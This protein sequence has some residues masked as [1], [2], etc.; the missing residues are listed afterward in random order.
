MKVSD[1]MS[2]DLCTAG[3]ESTLSDAA[4]LMGEHGVGSVL[5]L[6]GGRLSGILTERDIV[7]ALST[8]HDGPMRPATEWMTKDPVTVTPHV[9]VRTAL[10]TMIEGG[11]RHLPVCEGDT[12]IGVLSIRDVAA[13][14]AD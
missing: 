6:D 8:A 2:K 3:A 13:A 9:E 10:Q 1:I 5:I 14:L 4:T 7:R 11:F 12:P